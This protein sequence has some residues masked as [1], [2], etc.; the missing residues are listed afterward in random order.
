MTNRVVIVGGGSAGW[1]TAGLLASRQGTAVGGDLDV[2]LIESPDVRTIGVG[3]GTW[4]TMRATLRQIGISESAFIE[5][6]SAA[7]KQGTRF[8]GWVTGDADD[9]YYHPFSAPAG[10]PRFDVVPHWQKRRDEV[11]FVDA[12]T[13]QGKACDL[14]LAPKDAGAPEY[15]AL[16]NYGYHLDAGKFAELLQLHCT[17]QLGVRHVRDHVT[18]VRGTPEEDIQGLETKEN[19][20]LEADLF[21]DCTGMAS[22]LLGQHYG[23]PFIDRSDVLFNDRALAVQVP[24]AAPD[25]PVA[26]QTIS[27]AQDAGWIWDIGLTSR[28]G[29]GYTYS[30]R[31][32]DSDSATQTL[33]AYLRRTG[34]PDPDA[35]SPREIVFQSGHRERF[36]H[37]NCV[38]VG[39]SA[40]FLEPLEASAL[41][42]IEL[43]AGMIAERLPADRES[44]DLVAGRF[45][46]TFRYR[47][48]RIIEFLKLHYVL[49]RRTGSAYWDDHRDPAT[50]PERL[51]ELLILWRHH[52]PRPND[53]DRMDEVFS[54]A[55]YQ[56]VLYGMGFE[57]RGRQPIAGQE[58]EARQ[59]FRTNQA[60]VRELLHRL[61]DHRALL[62]NG[63]GAMVRHATQ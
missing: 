24:Y 63:A 39:L 11:S 37:R 46:E 45:N 22:L 59:L 4:P 61:P 2:T 50:I 38:A 6:C 12:V 41:V 33:R 58:D 23:V 25:A 16:L 34:A 53:F 32:C 48:D 14:A 35:V 7:F 18:G 3:E 52:F 21:V 20:C 5:H 19:G 57:T 13:P 1:I 27:T 54:A 8:A 56:Y 40:G 55:S 62:A 43:S 9:V 28:R 60:Q 47:W 26:S 10:Y 31:H 36:W 17:E 44:M 42:L 29:V 49:S 30:S 15:A 51:Q